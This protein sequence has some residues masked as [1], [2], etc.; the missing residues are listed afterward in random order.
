MSANNPGTLSEGMRPCFGCVLYEAGGQPFDA[1]TA[2]AVNAEVTRQ[3]SGDSL[4]DQDDPTPEK[5]IRCAAFVA[6]QM[7]GNFPQSSNYTPLVRTGR[8]LDR[9]DPQEVARYL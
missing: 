2:A 7:C 3:I 5:I 8:R 6:I 4:R 1:D 9:L